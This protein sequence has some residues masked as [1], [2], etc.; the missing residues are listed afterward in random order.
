[1]T[2]ADLHGETKLAIVDAVDG[3]IKYKYQRS[4]PDPYRSGMIEVFTMRVKYLVH[5]VPIALHYPYAKGTMEYMQFKRGCEIGHNEFASLT[6]KGVVI[7]ELL[8]MERR[9]ASAYQR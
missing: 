9:H 5:R 4:F 3:L 6:Q 7:N 2:N 1:M 8:E